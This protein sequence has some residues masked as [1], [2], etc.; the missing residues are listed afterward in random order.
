MRPHRTAAALAAA[1]LGGS[2]VVAAATPAAARPDSL[3]HHLIAAYDFD[4]PVRGNPAG[5]RDRGRSGTAID[6]VNGGA[7]MRVRDGRGH[8]LQTGQRP[9]ANDDWKAGTYSATGVTSLRAFNAVREVTIMGWFKTTG[10][11]PSPNTNTPE[12]D[13]LYNA[14]G[15]AGILSGNSAGHDVRALLE[16]INVSGE[17]R[18]VALARRVDGSASQTFAASEPWQSVLPPNTWVHLTA[19]F[20]FDNAVMRLYK[21]GRPLDGFTTVAGDPWAVEGP[22]EPDVTTATDPRGIK[23]G[24]S[25]PQ[26]DREQNPCACRMDGLKFFD[27]ALTGREVLRLAR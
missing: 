9:G 10:Q 18:V 5:E 19:T 15:L 13:D 6:L 25:F 12:P 2:L 24:G 23:I 14:V 1:A 7:A 8:A 20:D 3:R 17:L 11:N 16:V 4:H 27:R 21:N 22:P 26:N